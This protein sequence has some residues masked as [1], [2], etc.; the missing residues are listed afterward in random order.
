MERWLD[1]KGSDLIPTWTHRWICNLMALPG[2]NGNHLSWGQV[3]GSVS[4]RVCP[5]VMDLGVGTFL[6]VISEFP[7]YHVFLPSCS[8]SPHRPVSRGRQGLKVSQCKTCLLWDC[9]SSLEK[10]AQFPS[11][12]AQT[13]KSLKHCTLLCPFWDLMYVTVPPSPFLHYF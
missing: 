12:K 1:H 9:S 5:W 8:L 3:G 2:S 7:G 11:S 6:W 4:T 10:S 13:P